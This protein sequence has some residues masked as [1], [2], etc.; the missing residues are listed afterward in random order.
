M[1]KR[2]LLLLIINFTLLL[3][4]FFNPYK[5]IVVV[6]NSM[7]PTF[8][9]G[10]ILLAKKYDVIRKNDV[11]VADTE[12]SGIIVKRVSL[13]PGE[14]YYFYIQKQ[15]I[16]LDDSYETINTFKK[17]HSDLTLFD[18]KLSNDRY[19][20]IGDNYNNSEDSR[21]FGPVEKNDIKYKVIN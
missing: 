20:L 19:F 1:K 2:L 8:K 11:V 6:G 16:Y 15:R 7:Y 13:I 18:F 10:Q 9:H 4:L 5:L 21:S 14:H 17:S 12:Y 3:F